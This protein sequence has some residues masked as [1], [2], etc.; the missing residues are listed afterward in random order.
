[1]K[2]EY[3]GNSDVRDFRTSASDVKS[4]DVIFCGYRVNP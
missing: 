3:K 2:Q 1:M 4:Y